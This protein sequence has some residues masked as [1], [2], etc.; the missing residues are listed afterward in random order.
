MVEI[1]AL[2]EGVVEGVV[3]GLHRHAEP[4]GGLAVDLDER[5]QAAVLGLGDDLAQPGDVAQ[6]L[7]Q[8]AGP[9]ETSS[10]LL[11]ISVYWNCA[12]LVRVL[13]WMSWTGWK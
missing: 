3:D 8:Q 2:A 1:L 12:R 10:A 11:P 5:A 7:D 9:L 13:I 4:A 6:L